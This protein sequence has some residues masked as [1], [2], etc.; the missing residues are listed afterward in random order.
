[1]WPFGTSSWL[2]ECFGFS[3]VRTLGSHHIYSHP[4]VPELINVQ[5]V[6]SK[7]KPY[8]IRQFLRLVRRYKLKP[9][10][11]HKKR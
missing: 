7:A 8:Q 4:G 2:V 1:M 6:R 11:E 10:W 9:V 3:R 5:P